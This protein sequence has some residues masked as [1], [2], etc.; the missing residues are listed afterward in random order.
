MAPCGLSS[1]GLASAPS[2]GLSECQAIHPQAAL[3][4]SVNSW[5][6][7]LMFWGEWLLLWRLRVRW[8][9]PWEIWVM[10]RELD[11]SLVLVDRKELG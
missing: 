3:P 9:S 7:E 2:R 10:R 1:L 8:A 11:Q 4:R 5:L 6:C